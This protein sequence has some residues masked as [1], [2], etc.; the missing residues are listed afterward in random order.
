MDMV[1]SLSLSLFFIVL[2]DKLDDKKRQ[3][4]TK[5][6]NFNVLAAAA[7][8]KLLSLCLWM[9]TYKLNTIELNDFVSFGDQLAHFENS[10]KLIINEKVWVLSFFSFRFNFTK[11]GSSK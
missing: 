5:N 8:I 4:Q 9:K 1:V 2:D 3:T 10:L 7:V 6:S 11:L